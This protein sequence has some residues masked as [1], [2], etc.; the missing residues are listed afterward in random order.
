MTSQLNLRKYAIVFV[1]TVF[2]LVAVGFGL[3]LVGFPMPP[4]LQTWLPA[5][6]AALLVGQ[7]LVREADSVPSTSSYWKFGAIL[8]VV[9]IALHVIIATIVFVGLSAMA[10][11]NML[12][13]FAAIGPVG[14]LVI[15]GVM[16]LAIYFSNV[17]FLWMGVKNALRAQSRKAGGK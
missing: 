13:Q 8:T 17:F 10:G 6:I 7:G 4:G 3:N 11:V 16:A 2:G 14:L 5:A 9:A 12:S 1:I 15:G